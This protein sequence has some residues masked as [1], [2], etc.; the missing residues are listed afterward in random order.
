MQST[1][2]LVGPILMFLIVYLSM[3]NNILNTLAS[4]HTKLNAYSICSEKMMDSAFIGKVIDFK[5]CYIHELENISPISCK[6]A[7]NK[8]FCKYNN[9]IIEYNL[10]NIRVKEKA[11]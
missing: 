7:N 6:L 5:S 11:K 10:P 8:I 1:I 4:L 9:T 3:F 2:Y